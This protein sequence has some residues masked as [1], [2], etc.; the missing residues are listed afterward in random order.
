MSKGRREKKNL[1]T[2]WPYLFDS[3]LSPR[4]SPVLS[5]ISV[6]F[7]SQIILSGNT[8]IEISTAPMFQTILKPVKLTVYTKHHTLSVLRCLGILMEDGEHHENKGP[9]N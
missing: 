4:L 8:V 2:P 7:P 1:H 5:T 3:F 9:L 6:D